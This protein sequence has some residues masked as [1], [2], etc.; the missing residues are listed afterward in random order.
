MAA[1]PRC[2]W[3]WLAGLLLPLITG[4]SLAAPPP[5]VFHSLE[6]RQDAMEF[7]PQWLGVLERHLRLDVADGDCRQD[8]INQCHLQSWLAFLRGIKDKSRAEQR[9]EVN[10]YVNERPYR[11]DLDTYG[12][13]DYWA[14]VK[15]FL[16]HGGDCEDFAISKFFSLR[17]L[18][19]PADDLRL[20]LVQDT[21]LRVQHAVLIVFDS[22]EVWVLDNQSPQ[23]MPQDTIVHYTPLYSVNEKHWWLHVPATAQ[24]Q[25]DPRHD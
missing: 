25:G 4:L 11:L 6:E 20:L 3:L 14:V 12:Q 22:G 1:L 9:Q 24:Q 8:T 13:D 19:V 16:P 10:R 23:V 15:E 5:A 2:S 17:W 7:L 18:G 21:N